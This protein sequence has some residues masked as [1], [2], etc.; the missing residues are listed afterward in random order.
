LELG[1]VSVGG[2]LSFCYKI[3]KK[4]MLSPVLGGIT[5]ARLKER[6]KK[7]ASKSRKKREFF[8]SLKILSQVKA[9]LFAGLIGVWEKERGVYGGS[10]GKRERLSLEESPRYWKGGR[11][12]FQ[13]KVRGQKGEEETARLSGGGENDLAGTLTREGSKT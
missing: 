4:R 11:R 13:K 1:A 12:R 5:R 9:P 6:G 3:Q 2:A 10:V 8:L 7:R